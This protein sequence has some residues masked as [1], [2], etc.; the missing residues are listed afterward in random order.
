MLALQ[1]LAG[2]DNDLREKLRLQTPE[3][4]EY[5]RKSQCFTR[6]LW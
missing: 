5:L 6:P 4:Y 2:A 3:D 1:L